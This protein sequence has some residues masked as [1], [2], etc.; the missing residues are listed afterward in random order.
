MF[1]FIINGFSWLYSNDIISA[2]YSFSAYLLIT[3]AYKIIGNIESSQI[4]GLDS[5]EMST[6]FGDFICFVRSP[7]RYVYVGLRF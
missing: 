7:L 6:S 1:P 4:Y 5:V 2:D 3:F